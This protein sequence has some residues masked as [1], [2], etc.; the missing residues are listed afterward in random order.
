MS[1][2][3]SF[4]STDLTPGER[5]LW[6]GRPGRS[7][8]LRGSVFLLLFFLGWAAFAGYAM[9]SPTSDGETL[10]APMAILFLLAGVWSIGGLYVLPAYQQRH[11]VYG[12]TDRRAIIVVPRL[13]GGRH[14]VNIPLRTLDQIVLSERSDGSGSIRFGPATSMRQ[15]SVLAD[16]AWTASLQPTTFEAIP[17]ARA[18]YALLMS[19]LP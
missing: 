17:E 5:L 8:L 4:L 9:R 12:V 18:V 6:S 3:D 10:P 7:H 16:S 13:R 15:R 1:T 11:A 14:V 19:A 2:V